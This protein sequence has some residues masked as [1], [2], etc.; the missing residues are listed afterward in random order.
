MVFEPAAIERILS[1]SCPETRPTPIDVNPG[2]LDTLT[3]STWPMGRP[4]LADLS[5]GSAA[6]CDSRDDPGR[7]AGKD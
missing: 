4:E 3:S 1:P 7:Q 6:I 2:A 5:Q